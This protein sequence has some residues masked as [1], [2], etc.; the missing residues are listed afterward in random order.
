MKR[1]FIALW[2]AK[3]TATAI[4]RV[5][6]SWA[7]PERCRRY[8]PRDLHL[9]LHFIGAC[10]DDK[11]E[12]LRGNLRVPMES[13]TLVLDTL[14]LWPKGLAVLCPSVIP[15]SLIRLHEA[16]AQTLR[17]SGVAFDDRRLSPHVTLARHC[18]EVTLQD[19]CEPIPW[20]VHQCA[21]VQSTGDPRQ[22]YVALQIYGGS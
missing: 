16:L 14:R 2:P 9:T 5:A 8:P 17:D 19:T 18:Q 7:W 21:L 20:T 22:R 1:I 15:E 10:P 6:A 4:D 12:A 3:R 13:F 11:V